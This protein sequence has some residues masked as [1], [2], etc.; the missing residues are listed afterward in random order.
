MAADQVPTEA[1]TAEPA[2][3]RIV[4]TVTQPGGKDIDW[5]KVRA[6]GVIAGGVIAYGAKTR[7]WRTVRI[8]ATVVTIGAALA[9]FLNDKVVKAAAAPENEPPD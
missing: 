9:G 3:I 6:V 8:A 4:R 1:G 5:Q 7:K 2:V